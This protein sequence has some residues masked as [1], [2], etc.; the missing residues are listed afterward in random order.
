MDVKNKRIKNSSIF[1][2]I[3]YIIKR[4]KKDQQDLIKKIAILTLKGLNL[5][6][7]F[8]FLR[9]PYSIFFIKYTS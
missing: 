2:K 1:K 4:K 3:K 8:L 7:Y 6:G 5:P 9:D